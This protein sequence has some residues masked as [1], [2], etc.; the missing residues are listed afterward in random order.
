VIRGNNGDSTIAGGGGNDTLT[1]FGGQD[2]FFFNA[3]LDPVS[4][5][6]QITDF[7]LTDDTIIWRTRCSRRSP[8]RLT[9]RAT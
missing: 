3:A 8:P 2:L 7:S 1:G 5:V 6:D 9:S 4:N